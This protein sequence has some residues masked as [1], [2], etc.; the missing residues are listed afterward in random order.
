MDFL[1]KNGFAVGLGAGGLVALG[2]L[3]FLV[4][5]KIFGSV[6]DSRS[7]LGKIE[8]DYKGFAK[9]EVVPSK[10]SK[11][12]LEVKK[13]MWDEAIE[14]ASKVYDQ[15]KDRFN[16]LLDE[17]VATGGTVDE[18]ASFKAAY[19]SKVE[20]LRAEYQ[21]KF[22]KGPAGTA[23]EGAPPTTPPPPEG[24]GA[25]GAGPPTA[26]PAPGPAPAPAP[27][28]SPAPASPKD[29]REAKD[30]PPVIQLF[31]RFNTAEDVTRAMRELWII[32]ELF[33]A[34]EELNLGGLQEVN[35]P[36]RDQTKTAADPNAP[37]EY[38]WVRARATIDMPYGDVEP[39][40]D[41]IF[42]SDR[43]PLRL[44]SL[45]VYRKQ[46]NVIVKLVESKVYKDDGEIEAEPPDKVVSEPPVTVVLEL[47]GLNWL[48]PQAQ[49][50]APKTAKDKTEK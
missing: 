7:S 47:S 9:M 32:I 46:E 28:P 3:W 6:S 31:P 8:K 35:F 49:A 27:A 4:L 2:L 50:E 42:K 22:L 44:D 19:T 16:E 24:E 20:K 10:R 13:K 18:P 33:G 26:P 5:G 15:K 40:L 48:G 37:K 38:N 29:T 11:G 12:V 1:K 21:K 41:R 34:L 23:P 39:L 45:E 43:V 25:P 14:S 36:D 30:I 17:Y